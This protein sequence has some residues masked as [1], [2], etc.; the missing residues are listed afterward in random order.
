MNAALKPTPRI[1]RPPLPLPLPLQRRWVR[2]A[3]RIFLEYLNSF[4]ENIATPSFKERVR[5]ILL[6]S[7]LAAFCAILCAAIPALAQGERPLLIGLSAEYG[8]SGSQTAQSIEK[9]I[10]L[11]IDEINTAGGVLGRKLALEKRD[12]RGLPARALD[13]LA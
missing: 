11:A 4:R 7:L 6:G 12:D 8:M 5:S 9:G 1:N 13:N 10:L 3:V 2:S